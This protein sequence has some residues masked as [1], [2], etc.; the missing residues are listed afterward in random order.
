MRDELQIP[1]CRCST[2]I[3]EGRWSDIKCEA[4][5]VFNSTEW[6]KHLHLCCVSPFFLF[7]S[8]RILHRSLLKPAAVCSML[9]LPRF[10]DALA[11]RGVWVRARVC[12]HSQEC[13]LMFTDAAKCVFLCWNLYLDMLFFIKT[14]KTP[15]SPPRLMSVSLSADFMKSQGKHNVCLQVAAVCW[16]EPRWWTTEDGRGPIHVNMMTDYQFSSAVSSVKRG[17]TKE[18]SNACLWSKITHCAAAAS[19]FLSRSLSSVT[20]L[21]SSHPAQTLVFP[22]PNLQFEITFHSFIHSLSNDSHWT[23]ATRQLR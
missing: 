2:W 23:R 4:S 7:F 16:N 10:S 3:H 17:E 5:G 14:I 18:S 15:T 19:G 6:H 12:V 20:S 1:C 11:P 8:K 13:L 9:L 22:S 21:S